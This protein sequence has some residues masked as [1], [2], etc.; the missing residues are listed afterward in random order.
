MA[1][2]IDKKE[3]YR[4]W[5]LFKNGQDLVE[6]RL[7]GK[8]TYSGYYKDI[9]KLISDIERFDDDLD[10]QMYYTLNSIDESCFGRVQSNR[11]MMNPKTTTTDNDI[12]GR[13]F[14]LVDLDPKRKTG[15]NASD[16]E[17]EY[18][19]IKAVQIY[20]FL[21]ANGFNEPIVC[22]SGNGWHLNIPCK[23]AVNAETDALIKRFLAALSMLFSDD[24]VEVDEKVF[25]RARISKLY[26]TTAKK[27]ANIPERPHRMSRIVK[28][29]NEIKI[30]DLEYFKKI[31][32]LYPVPDEST[33]KEKYYSGGQT[34]DL[35]EFINKHHIQVTKVET[36]AGGK[37]YILD[38]CCFD[39]SHK[40][41]DAVLFKSDSGAISYVCLHNSCNHYHWK[42]FRL[43][44]EPD[45]YDRKDYMEYQHK[46]RYYGHPQVELY[47][48]KEETKEKGKKWKSL[49]D[50]KSHDVSEDVYIP[51]GFNALD[52]AI[53][54]LILGEVTVVSG[55]NGSGKSSWLNV[56]AAN[57]IQRDFKVAIW[58]GELVDFKLKGWLNLVLA[59]KENVEPVAGCDNL[60][61][62][63]PKVVP[64]I[65]SWTKDKLL[66]YNNDY[67]NKYEQ[68]IHDMKEVIPE[69]G[70]S[71]LIV[72]NLMA[73][74]I[75]GKEGS[76]YDKQK[77]FILEICNLAKKYQVH[78]I[79]VAHPRKENTLLRKES[80]SGTADLTNAADNVILC[81]RCGEDFVK[82]ASEFFGKAKASL[83]ENYSNVL[84]V[85]K[86]RS[87]GVV[88]YLVG[89]YYEM[90]TKRFKNDKSEHIR[91][92]W[93]E[94][95]KQ[96]P[97]F[98]QYDYYSSFN[99]YQKEAGAD[100]PFAPTAENEEVPF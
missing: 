46:M 37:K 26:G 66:I 83:Y 45:A 2:M 68:I 98:D 89:T 15:V 88:D 76:K 12:I 52:R 62:V 71:L 70:I 42:D 73:L 4:W 6:I 14:V 24:N 56:L 69:K 50:I 72:D 77:E 67:G 78:V 21:L 59:G 93:Q 40:G 55:L 85:C 32:D 95:P 23:I 16:E 39:E 44:F 48:P 3:I 75:D 87:M 36:V 17:L 19:H 54:G 53:R 29:P 7:L 100:M 97:I 65:D 79:L 43:H 47:K 86:N 63:I 91:Y 61:R 41:K 94:T 10:E 82:R 51:T 80:I 27:G 5:N 20:K 13:N 57:A 64:I 9:D 92:G 58:S 28:A 33:N 74:D 18:A 38:H 31:A 34:F 99:G 96:E 11:L 30:N 60:Y 90:E 25:N 8:K 81:H 22:M 35:D 84:E 49:I 1:R